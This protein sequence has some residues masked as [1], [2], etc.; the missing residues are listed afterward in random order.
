MRQL[1]LFGGVFLA[2]ASF[3][4]CDG[5]GA[6]SEA[7]IQFSNFQLSNLDATR[8]DIA[9]ETDVASSCVI[10]FGTTMNLG[11]HATDPDMEEG[12]TAL[13]HAVPVEDLQ[14][15]TTYYY[16]AQAT[17][18]TGDSAESEM[19]SFQT[20][21]ASDS[22]VGR[23]NVALLSEGTSIVAVSSNYGGAANDQSWGIDNAFDGSMASEWSSD[24][25]GSEAFVEI[26]FGQVRNLTTFAFR[27]RKMNDQSSITKELQLRAG[28]TVLGPFRTEDPDQRYIV[29]FDAPLTTERIRIEYLDSTGGNT[30]AKE[31]EFYEAP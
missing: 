20:L 25:D 9:F 8:V 2:L 26:D 23:Q 4:A 17:S 18:A 24:F 30:G 31:I 29:D 12:E 19:F 11:S 28:Q 22:T 10:E 15:G 13:L 21:A 27:S 1:S 14:P 16:L 6:P 3:L 5:G 7:V